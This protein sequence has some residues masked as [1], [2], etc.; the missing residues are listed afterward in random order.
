MASLLDTS[1]LNQFSSVFVVLFIFTAGYAVLSFK[2]PFG[3]S[4]GINALLAFTM[5]IITLFVPD[6]IEV[7]KASV[8]WYIVMMIALMFVVLVSSSIGSGIPKE[9]MTNIGG[10]VLI[11]SIVILIINIGLRLGQ[12]AGPFLGN[13]VTN[14]DNVVA[15]GTGDVAS[16]SFTQNFGATLFHPKVL[17]LLLIM[18]IAAFSIL[19][20]GYV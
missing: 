16:G 20:I 10:W 1:L 14:P 7:V 8:P 17:A 15:G 9:V 19:W 13:N 12:G 6:A 5:A 18:V 11:I 3:T 2:G 4:K